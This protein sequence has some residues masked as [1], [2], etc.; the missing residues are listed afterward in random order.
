MA[1][2]VATAAAVAAEVATVA[3]ASTTAAQMAAVGTAARE[4]YI[5]KGRKRRSWRQ[6]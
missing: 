4:I 5:K 3:M 2:A 1:A 6:Q